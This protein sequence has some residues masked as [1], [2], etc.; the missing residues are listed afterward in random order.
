MERYSNF[1]KNIEIDKNVSELLKTHPNSSK[2]VNEVVSGYEGRIPL[3]PIV[4]V[5][6]FS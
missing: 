3:N 6:I 5:K 4:E 1:Q 2:R